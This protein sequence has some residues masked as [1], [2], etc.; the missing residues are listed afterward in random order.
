[1]VVPANNTLQVDTH[2]FLFDITLLFSQNVPL[3]LFS[4]S[5]MHQWYLMIFILF[6]FSPYSYKGLGK[7]SAYSDGPKSK[8]NIWK[9]CLLGVLTWIMNFVKSAE[10]SIGF[11]VWFVRL[12]T[13]VLTG[14]S[15]LLAL[16]QTRLSL[17]SVFTQ[18][19]YHRHDE[20]Q[21]Q[22]LKRLNLAWIQIFP[23]SKSI[24]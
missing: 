16:F 10:W 18:P 15:K 8:E 19:F 1:M 3:P 7:I 24:A 14:F 13:W 12:V 2:I 21:D 6:S 20:R 4:E 11:W 9:K 5:R 23:S 17:V 22:F